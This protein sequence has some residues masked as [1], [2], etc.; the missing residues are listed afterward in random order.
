M[1]S[2]EQAQPQSDTTPLP[3]GGTAGVAQPSSTTTPA[4]QGPA[5][6]WSRIKR[7]KVAEWTLAYAAFGFALVHGVAI[8]SDA[9][10][11]PHAIVHSLT[12]ALILG[13]PIA[14]VVAWYHGVRALKRVSGSELLIITLLLVIGGSLLWIVPR[15]TAQHARTDAVSLA[16]TSAKPESTSAVFAPPSHSIAVL[17]FLNMSGDPKQEYFSDGITEELLNSLSRLSELRVVARTSS[18]SFKGKD[19]DAST[20]GHKLNVGSLLEGSVRRS[21]NTVRITAQLINTVTGFHVWSQTYDRRLTDILKVQTDVASAVA[22][23]LAVELVGDEANRIELGGT[24]NPEAYDAYLYGMQLLLS[25]GNFQEVAFR[26][27]LTAFDRAIALDPNYARAYIGRARVLTDISFYA[28]TPATRAWARPQ[29]AA[30]AE[31]AV[32][33][34]PQLGEAHLELARVRVSAFMDLAGAAPEYERAVELSPGSARVWQNVAYFHQDLGHHREALDAGR[35]AVTLDPL[36]AE[37]HSAVASALLMVRQFREAL[38]AFEDAMALRPGSQYI[39]AGMIDAVLALNDTEKA[40]RQCESPSTPLD[41]DDRHG[42]LAIAY[43]RLGREEDGE[44]ELRTLKTLDGD[45]GAYEYARIYAQWGDNA[46]ALRWLS[47][48]EQL[49]DRGLLGLRDDWAIDPIR[50][51]P[52][53]KAILARMNFPP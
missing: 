22:Q 48:A 16:T 27:P 37:S 21:G 53:F 50:N 11:W 10:E 7:H 29:A 3:I 32:A 47:K 28:V 6:L 40:R 36:N 5:W 15:P 42:C 44:R 17:P 49:R 33:I 1:A 25:N 52:Q 14:P 18:F 19:V 23:Q 43:H 31:K 4:S 51:E 39:E 41:E 24:K 12:L 46:A 20:I 2:E 13:L 35:R 9:L 45:S 26:A 30:A 8:L 34:A 38:M